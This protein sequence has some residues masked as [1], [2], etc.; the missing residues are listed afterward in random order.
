MQYQNGATTMPRHPYSRWVADAVLLDADALKREGVCVFRPPRPPTQPRGFTAPPAV[1]APAGGS[2]AP[3]RNRQPPL[4]EHAR[5]M[6]WTRRRRPARRRHVRRE[7]VHP[8]IRLHEAPDPEERDDGNCLDL[9]S[10]GSGLEDDMK[11][12]GA[13]PCLLGADVEE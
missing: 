9:I 8:G 11:G 5:R 12:V 10:C 7:I 3:G 13:V 6:I 4:S 2:T 1:K